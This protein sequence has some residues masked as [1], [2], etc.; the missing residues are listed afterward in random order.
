MDNLAV[1]ARKHGDLT[2]AMNAKLNTLLQQEV[3]DDDGQ[4]LPVGHEVDWAVT[5]FD[6]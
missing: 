3:G 4:F 5:K 6:P 1:D 2:L